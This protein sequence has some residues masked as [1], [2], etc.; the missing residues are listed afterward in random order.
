MRKL[1]R[2]ELSLPVAVYCSND[3]TA[4]EI[5]TTTK[6]VSA[7]GALLHLDHLS[8]ESCE[9][10]ER[11]ELLIEISISGGRLGELMGTGHEVRVIIGGR[12]VR[13]G[14]SGVAVCFAG[15]YRFVTGA[16]A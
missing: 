8:P 9:L 15:R 14:R 6:N 2:Y 11:S 4:Q 16:V 5:T 7:D 1:C 10:L 12:V 3:G 13:S